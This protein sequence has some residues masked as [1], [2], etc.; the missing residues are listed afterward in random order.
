MAR[1][2]GLEPATVGIGIRYSIQLRYERPPDN[3]SIFFGICKPLADYLALE[4]SSDERSAF[5]CSKKPLQRFPH[6]VDPLAD[7]FGDQ[8]LVFC[9]QV[10]AGRAATVDH[11]AELGGEVAVRTAAR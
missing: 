2:T 8:V 4:K 5:A 7:R 3:S 6:Q 11:G 10:S 9:V 1:S